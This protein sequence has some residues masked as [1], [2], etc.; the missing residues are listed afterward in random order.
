VDL[1]TGERQVWWRKSVPFDSAAI[2]VEQ[3][4]YPSKDGTRISMFLV[5]RK[6]LKL[7][8][9]ALGKPTLEDVF[10]RVTGHGFK[11]QP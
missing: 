10:I 4:G 6:G 1:V 5:H 7:D 11:D 2:E 3:V 8:G 9:G